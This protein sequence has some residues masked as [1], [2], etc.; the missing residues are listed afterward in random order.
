MI[1]KSVETLVDERTIGSEFRKFRSK[2]RYERKQ[3]LHFPYLDM[4]KKN[5]NQNL[6][7]PY[8]SR[9]NILSKLF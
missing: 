8:F 9:V 1:M 2:F 6:Y 4:K 5:Q 7:L 3:N